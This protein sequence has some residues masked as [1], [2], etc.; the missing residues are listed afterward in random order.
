M[1]EF[2]HNISIQALSKSNHSVL[3]KFESKAEL[4]KNINLLLKDKIFNF[5]I[6]GKKKD[7]P[8]IYTTV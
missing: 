5:K 3:L 1:S 8:Q 4:M 6:E 7:V 2:Y